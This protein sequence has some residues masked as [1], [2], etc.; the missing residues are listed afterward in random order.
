MSDI[1]NP[2]D[3]MRKAVREARD[4]ENAVEQSAYAM[5]NMLV[6]KLR[7]CDASDLCNL[8]KELAK[9]DMHRKEWKP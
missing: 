9:W 8:K 6:G 5:A 1:G 2:W 3:A 7:F 4:I